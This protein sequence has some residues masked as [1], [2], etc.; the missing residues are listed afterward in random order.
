MIWK[1]HPLD[2][3]EQAP[4]K[5]SFMNIDILRGPAAYR[6]LENEGFRSEWLR[7]CEQCSW[8]TAFQRPGFSCAWY[9]SYGSQFEPVLILSR[10]EDA[11]LNGLLALAV[12][13]KDGKLVV[14]GAAQ[15]EYQVWVCLPDLGEAFAWQTIQSLQRE[16]P[17]AALT[18]RYLP[19]ESPTGWLA[20]PEAKQVCKLESHRRPLLRFGDG[21]EIVKSL[22]KRHNK[23]R[24]NRLRRIGNVEFKRIV[25]LDEFEEIF[26]KIICYY[27]FRSAA[28]HG[29]TP[30][31]DDKF[32][33]PFHLA[34]MKWPGL[35]HVTVLNIGD[36][37]AGAHINTC[38]N[39]EVHLGVLAHNPQLAH[40]SPGAFHIYFLSQLLMKEGYQ[41][42]DLTPGGDRYK[43][44]FANSFD[45]VH[46]LTVFP[47]PRQRRRA[48]IRKQFRN[49]ARQVLTMV[50]VS[51]DCITLFVKRLNKVHSSHT[52]AFFSW[53]ARSWIGRRREVRVY[54]YEA[55]KL[56]SSDTNMSIHRDALADLLGYQPAEAWQSRQRFLS[57]SLARLKDGQHVYTYVENGRLLHYGW[58]T[59]RPD[60]SLCGDR[61]PRFTFPPNSAY[62]FDFYTFPQAR[63][64][65]LYT[66]CLRTILSELTPVTPTDK[67]YIA[68]TADNRPARHVIEKMGFTH[69]LSWNETVRSGGTGNGW[70]GVIETVDRG[71]T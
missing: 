13:P 21:E 6:L 20:A 14:A 8:A 5:Q 9:H 44:D 28:I 52:P 65:G 1:S 18:F 24:L 60:Q 37:L 69:E 61:L 41:Q 67:I 59:E 19:P 51:P 31:R 11:R 25:D 27:D 2:R 16:F 22:K 26:D 56:A 12:S 68:V 64:R 7:L 4:L 30:F 55:M 35:L 70:T 10:A 45:E 62:V 50:G 17:R 47:T 57:T 49:T 71:A 34:M 43:S 54:S 32:K 42:L 39:N 58:L 53:D 40:H 66:H 36:Q 23:T 29:L 48:D 63:G 33:K 15:A 46:T 38:G 3:P